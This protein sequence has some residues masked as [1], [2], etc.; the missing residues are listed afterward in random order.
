MIR[1]IDAAAFAYLRELMLIFAYFAIAFYV[2]FFAADAV[3]FS[4]FR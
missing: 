4:L 2:L 1:C 3:S